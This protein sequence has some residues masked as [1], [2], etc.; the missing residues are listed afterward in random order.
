MAPP[1]DLDDKDLAILEALQADGRIAFS[2]LG[3]QVGLSQ[4]AM[5]ERVKRLEDRGIIT[6]YG[7]RI[8]LPALGLRMAAILRLKTEHAQIGA[9][10]KQFDSLPH[11]VE[12]HRVTGDDCFILKALVPAPE[13]LA[14]IVD[15]I[16][17]FGPVTTSV[18]L[19]SE[20][21]KPV[22]RALLK[23]ARR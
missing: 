17:R 4:P 12:V 5:S 18:V 22:G 6:G 11:I 3:R 9:C 19:R 10:L 2:E 7:A 21:V 23:A 15:A 16:G 13:D 1:V 8:G 20:P 14:I